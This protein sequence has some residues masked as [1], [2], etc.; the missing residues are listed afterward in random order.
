MGKNKIPYSYLWD[1]PKKNGDTLAAW[2]KQQQ[3]LQPASINMRRLPG[4]T[5]GVDFAKEFGLGDLVDA[6]HEFLWFSVTPGTFHTDA[7]D[8]IFIHMAEEA[9]LL[10]LPSNCSGLIVPLASQGIMTFLRKNQTK[11]NL[12]APFFHMRMKPGDGFTIPSGAKHKVVARSPHRV[13]VNAFFEPKFRQMQ[14]TSAPGNMYLRNHPDVLAARNLWV[15]S[16]RHLWD[17]EKRSMFY[18]TTRMGVI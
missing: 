3:V 6:T 8:N 10:V 15:K 16:L 5:E 12:R 1:Q 13:S 7:Y 4:F 2:W 18:H 9:D 14:W 11:G 17:T